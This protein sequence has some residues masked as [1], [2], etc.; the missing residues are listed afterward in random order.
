MTTNEGSNLS[1]SLLNVLCFLGSEMLGRA[2]PLFFF[3]WVTI[4]LLILV[5]GYVLDTDS[6]F[7]CTES[8]C[9]LCGLCVLSWRCFK[10]NRPSTFHIVRYVLLLLFLSLT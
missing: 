5:L 3:S 1:V 4:S 6:R 10:M 8:I 2:L 7:K 9:F